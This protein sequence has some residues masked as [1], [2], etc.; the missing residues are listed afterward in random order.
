MERNDIYVIHGR[1]YQEMTLRILEACDLAALIGDREKSIA[2]K[3]NLVTTTPPEE[4]ATTHPEILAGVI[5]YLQAHGFR[6]LTVMESA[7]AGARTEDVFQICY[8]NRVCERY[9]VPFLDM[10]K[11]TYQTYDA[12]GMEIAVC[13]RAMAVDFMINLPVLKGHCQTKITCALKNNKGIIPDFEKR[14]FHTIGLHQPIAHLNTVCKNDFILVD[15]ICGDLEFEEGGNP[16]VMNRIL[17]FRDPVLCDAFVCDAMGYAVDDVPYVRI[18]ER[19]GIGST[20]LSSANRIRVNEPDDEEE[21]ASYRP[22]GR[23]ARLMKHTAPDNACSACIGALIRA[24][25]RT[26][27][28]GKLSRLRETVCVG[29]AYR[30]KTGRCG[31]GNCT[32]GFEKS[33][34]GCPPSAAEILA[35]LE[36]LT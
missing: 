22:S 12:A 34:R 32:A 10:K 11:D 26:E 31:V 8:H 14:R 19:L 13:D 2:L 9:G 4:G 5:E 29:Q 30:G 20:D 3:P 24:L 23:V 1:A 35:F 33:V 15:N 6:N 16:V 27:Q 21:P 7:W 25:H 36:T 17:A 28:Q 18:A